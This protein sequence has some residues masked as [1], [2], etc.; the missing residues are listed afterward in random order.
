M[1]RRTFLIFTILAGT[2]VAAPLLYRKYHYVL[3]GSPLLYPSVLSHI[4][5][6]EMLRQIGTSYRALFPQDNSEEQ[7]LALLLNDKAVKKAQ[8]SNSPLIAEQLEREIQKDF[9][10]NKTIIING[11]VLS[12]TEARQC[13]LLSFN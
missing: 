8:S 9:S 1:K 5:S 4:C 6:D 7:L 13:A 12:V 11:W 2:T 10:D 3:S